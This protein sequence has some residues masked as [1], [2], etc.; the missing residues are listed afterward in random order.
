MKAWKIRN[1]RNTQ[2]MRKPWKAK[3]TWKI[4]KMR[5]PWKAR[6]IW[7]IQKNRNTQ[8]AW[9]TRKTRAEKIRQKRLAA[10]I[11]EWDVQNWWRA[12]TFWEEM[13]LSDDVRGK[14]VLD[15][16]GRNG[17]LSLY[18][19][20]K[21][22]DV[23]C[24]D[25]STDGLKKAKQLHKKYRGIT[26]QITYETIDAMEIPYKNEFDLI[27]FKSV[28]GGIGHDG[29]DENIRRALHSM[30]RALKEH[31]TLCF[32]EN[33]SASPLHQFARKK[34]VGWGKSWRYIRL[35]ELDGLLKEFSCTQYRTYGFFGVFGRRKWLSDILGA[36]DGCMD[37]YVRE[38][39]R[40]IV[41]C[42][43]RK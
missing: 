18:W 27:C 39:Y 12:V 4:Q 17:G 7:N 5:K 26:G 20:L 9:N 42:V 33:L 8:K 29:H 2:K 32:C 19:A 11:V 10:D 1:T 21:G 3:K 40:Y 35:P 30:H 13:H 15:I 14:K 28:L 24:S 23:I 22:A 41:S 38:E 34:C 6:K 16:G 31:G 43:S 37:R 25:I 36:I